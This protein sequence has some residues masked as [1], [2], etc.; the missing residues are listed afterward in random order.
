MIVD[1]T[2]YKGGWSAAESTKRC[3][4]KARIERVVDSFRRERRLHPPYK[5]RPAH[6]V[7]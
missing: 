4:D 2:A 3:G 5:K 6:A 1:A 7:A